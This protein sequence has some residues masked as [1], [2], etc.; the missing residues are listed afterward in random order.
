[1]PALASSVRWKWLRDGPASAD[2]YTRQGVRHRPVAAEVDLRWIAG[3]VPVSLI[4]ESVTGDDAH[5]LNIGS[6]VRRVRLPAMEAPLTLTGVFGA[7]SEGREMVP[8]LRLAG[9]FAPSC[10][11]AIIW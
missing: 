8:C 11:S 7:R 6:T 2:A 1:M 4:D 10:W 3:R 5:G 9:G